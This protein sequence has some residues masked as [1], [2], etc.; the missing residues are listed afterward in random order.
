MTIYTARDDR[1]QVAVDSR[2]QG[3]QVQVSFWNGE[4]FEIR[5]DGY[6][7]ADSLYEAVSD[8]LVQAGLDWELAD[9]YA[10][11]WGITAPDSDED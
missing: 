4:D 8:S 7:I 11:D 10:N 5:Q 1:Y 9:S 3:W 6:I 2:L